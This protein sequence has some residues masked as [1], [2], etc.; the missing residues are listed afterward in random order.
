[1]NT[2]IDFVLYV[3]KDKSVVIWASL[4]N[5][6]LKL[7]EGVLDRFK[8]FGRKVSGLCEVVD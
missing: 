2:L 1:M 7:T 4:L 3:R 8:V 6:F 5:I